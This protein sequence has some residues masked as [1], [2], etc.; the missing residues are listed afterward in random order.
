MTVSPVKRLGFSSLVC[1]V[2]AAALVAASPL[3]G[4]AQDAAPKKGPMQ[5]KPPVMLQP[6]AADSG[7]PADKPASPVPGQTVIRKS[8]PPLTPP[9]STGP[10]VQI[11]TLQGIDPDTA[12]TLT[13][14]Q[15]G[16]GEAMWSGTSR[17]LVVSLLPL[18]PVKSSSPVMRDLMHRLL[19]SA[20]AVPEGGSK[21]GGLLAQRVGL[22]SDM[23]DLTGVNEL[24]GIVPSQQKNENLVK[25]ETNARFLANDNARACTLTAR[26]IRE[27]DGQFWQ[28]S[29]IF[30]QALAGE[31]GKASLGVEL[32]RETS[33]SDQVF[34]TLIDAL[35][36]GGGTSLSSLSNP[37]PLHLSMAR[38]AKVS[39]P[40]DVISSNNPGILRTISISPNAPVELRLEAAERAESAGALPVDALRQLYTSVSFTDED[41]ANPLS[42][43]EAE[44]GPVSRALLYRTALIQ[45]VPTA[46]AEA[47]ARALALAREGGRYASTVRAFQPILGRLV[48]STDMIWFAPEA[49]RA[50]LVSGKAGL[51]RNWYELLRASSL[52]NPE[53]KQEMTA[54]LPLLYLSG[55]LEASEWQ[56]TTLNDWWQA[57]AGKEGASARAALLFSLFEA[58]GLP[59]PETLWAGLLAKAERSPVVMPHPAVWYGLAKAAES[60]RVGESVMLALIVLGEG[61]T[62]QANPV[63]LRRVLQSLSAVGLDGDARK[64]AIEAL[65]SNQ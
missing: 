30:C 53:A 47:T 29:F 33:D 14:E 36:G 38:A 28:K 5:L 49:I 31:A 52:F 4:W 45:T 7:P 13:A 41:L 21:S 58:F 16:F 2:L 19:L 48:P 59:V 56:E 10:G 61:G 60:R 37:S 3:S 15:G 57:Q 50:F 9:K 27:Y 18:L 25:L 65:V 23:G 32:L 35:T 39:L 62:R 54:L 51:A 11:D 8:P 12:G 34:F 6:P 20:A 24:L 44:S 46:Q 42:K 55:A 1:A 40:P 22:L 17:Q 43:A 26:H 64:M 63:I